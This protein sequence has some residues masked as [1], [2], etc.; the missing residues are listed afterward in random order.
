MTFAALHTRAK[1]TGFATNHECSHIGPFY[2]LKPG[3]HD[4]TL[5]VRLNRYVRGINF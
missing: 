5:V 2:S 4:A 1:F 3:A